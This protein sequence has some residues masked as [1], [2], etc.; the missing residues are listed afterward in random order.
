MVGIHPY[1]GKLLQSPLPDSKK[2]LVSIWAYILGFDNSC[3][4]ELIKE[5]SHTYFLQYLAAKDT[6]PQQRCKAAFVVS[7]I[8]DGYKEGQQLC[9]QQGLHRTCAALLAQKEGIVP[10]EL[11]KWLSFC[12]AK[13]FEGHLTVYCVILLSQFP[14]FAFTVNPFLFVVF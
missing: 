9:T 1:V 14:L 10:K 2:V 5:K 13:L 4:Q 3:R 12:M 8:C 7:A 11:K 6:V